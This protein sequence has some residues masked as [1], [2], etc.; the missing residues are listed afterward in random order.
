MINNSILNGNIEAG[1][2]LKAENGSKLLKYRT[3][4]N[5]SEIDN[6]L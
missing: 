3:S 5:I 2:L 4:N 6:Q 1:I